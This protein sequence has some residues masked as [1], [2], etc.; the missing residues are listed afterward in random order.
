MYLPKEIN[1][2]S[3]QMV[4]AGK[5][6]KNASIILLLYKEILEHSEY[7]S[8]SNQEKD[9]IDAIKKKYYSK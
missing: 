7:S 2:L 9:F 4:I 5:L 6:H 8:L 3:G 1:T